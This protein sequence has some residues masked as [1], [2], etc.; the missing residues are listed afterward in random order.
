MFSLKPTFMRRLAPPQRLRLQV[1][2]AR[3]WE[4][5]TDTHQTQCV[6]FVH[7]L[8]DR[9]PLEEALSRYFRE[10]AVPLAMRETVRARALL[11]IADN[12]PAV[13][14]AEGD[15]DGW[16]RLRPDR[17]LDSLRR[18][19]QF[20]EETTLHSRMA[21]S[22]ADEAVVETHTRMAVE[23]AELVGETMP[24]DE[25]V[26]LYIRTFDLPTKDGDAV[27]RGAMAEL[28]DQRLAVHQSPRVRVHAVETPTERRPTLVHSV[29]TP[30]F[31]LRVIG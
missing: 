10:V 14:P 2:Y 28:A 16:S 19:A 22:L 31:G 7:R 8:A 25:A 18:R 30:A 29:A 26:M 23:I 9:L 20:V 5:L 21:A 24:A 15:G 12:V 27:F 11:S 17:W 3:A 13:L 6:M 4:A 1:A